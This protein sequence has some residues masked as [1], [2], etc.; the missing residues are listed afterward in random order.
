M[1]RRNSSAAASNSGWGAGKIISSAPLTLIR[2][3]SNCE[4]VFNFAKYGLL[5]ARRSHSLR[6]RVRGADQAGMFVGDDQHR[7]FGQQWPEATLVA[8]RVQEAR[9]L[10]LGEDFDSNAAAD[11]DASDGNEAQRDVARFGA[12]VGAE[13]VQRLLANRILR[14]HPVMRNH[15]WGIA[16]TLQFLRELGRLRGALGITEKLVNV[17]EPFAADYPL[18]AYTSKMAPQIAVK[19]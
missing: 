18:V 10:Q 14:L 19:I 8:E 13:D 3:I 12:V 15:G 4:P 17:L 11:V 1:T 9:L 7:D 2:L 5:L 6:C 16:R